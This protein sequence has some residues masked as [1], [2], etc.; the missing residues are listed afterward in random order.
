MSTQTRLDLRGLTLAPAQVLGSVR[1]VPLLRT[2]I[3]GDLR[4]TQRRYDEY[5][6][7]VSLDGE[8]HARGPRYA[9]YIPHAYVVSWNADGTPLASFGTTLE[10]PSQ[11]KPHPRDGMLPCGGLVRLL[12]RMVK[13]EEGQTVRLLPLHLAMEGFLALHFGGPEIA[14]TEYS[15]QAISDGLSPRWETS[16][17]GWALSGLADALRVFEIHEGQTGVLVFVADALASVFIVP[18]PDDYRAL[19]RTLLEDFYGELLYRYG[20]LYPDTVGGEATLDDRSIGTL[21]DLRA[22]VAKMRADWADFGALLASG[23][24]EREI[25][26]ELVYRMSPFRLERFMTDL[27]LHEE[28]HIGEAILRDDGTI[29]YLKTFR[30]TDV[31]ARRAYLLKQLAAHGWNLDDT[32]AGLRSSKDELIRRLS[33]AGFGYLLKPHVLEAA[34]SVRKKRP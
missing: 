32:A 22:G 4:L 23:V 30:L 13:R 3:P 7:V 28:N 12:H 1:L 34:T 11:K 10:G 31:Q 33:N 18:H 6:G 27:K 25:S 26:A 16:M 24:L 20:Y 5:V 8:P 15:R 21:G 9:S 17:S 2:S 14:W 29:E 19:H